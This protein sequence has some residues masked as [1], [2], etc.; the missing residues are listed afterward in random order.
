MGYPKPK[1]MTNRSLKICLF[2]SFIFLIIVATVIISLSLTIFKPKNPDVSLYPIGL[3][4]LQFFQPNVTIVPLGLIITIVN[5]NYGGFK[6]KNTTG[7]LNYHKT[8]VANVSIK[9]E[10]LPARSTTNVTAIAGLM[11]QNLISDADFLSDIEDGSFNLTA[12]ATLH[13]KVHM[14]KVFKLKATVY[15]SCDMFFNITSFD[16]HSSCITKIKV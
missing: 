11:T 9:T 7:F 15:L 10:F 12:N 5:P 13:G 3:K 16:T 14:I 6:T 2:V 4:D 8:L 1:S